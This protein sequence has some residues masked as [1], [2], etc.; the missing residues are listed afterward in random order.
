MMNAFSPAAIKPFEPQDLERERVWGPADMSIARGNRLPAP[1]LPIEIFDETWGDLL[2]L[3]AH[4]K[5]APVDYVAASLL[6][7]A[8]ALLGNSVRGVPWEGWSEATALW[9]G[10]VGIPSSG[11]S[12]ALEVCADLLTRVEREIS[13]GYQADIINYETA[14]QSAAASKEK[15]KLETKEAVKMG[16]PVPAMPATALEP[17]QPIPPQIIVNDTTIEALAHILHGNPRGI[18][19]I[20]DEVSGWIGNLDR[21]GGVGG[22]RAFWLSSYGGRAHKV[23]RVKLGG[24]PLAIPFLNVSIL[25]GIQ[26][27]KLN[28]ALLTGED[29]GLCS[30]FCMVWPDIIPREVPK[31]VPNQSLALEAFRRLRAVPMGTA[32]DGTP[33]WRAVKFSDAARRIFEPWWKAQQKDVESAGGKLQGHFGKYPGFAVRLATIF[34]FLWWAVL[35]DAPEP[36][37]ISDVAVEAAVVLIDRYLKPMAMRCFG[38]AAIPQAERNAT[39]IAR[40][41]L[42]QRASRP[43]K[44]NARQIYKEASLP[45][46][47][48]AEPVKEALAVLVD[49]GWL[50]IAERGGHGRPA[51]DYD[52][53]PAVFETPQ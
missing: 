40:W 35:P 34:E 24:K 46:L 39:V 18:V 38:D 2:A 50:R 21:Y 1:K 32:V 44:I 16:R 48:S 7:S 29:D 20:A 25:G 6:C 42:A 27:D 41:I 28:S 49:H 17:E 33:Q 23:N 37:E 10:L 11:K 9:F 14:L 3:S 36:T 19:L 30:R 8:A 51:A 22:D 31:A 4:A 12:P 45:G 43:P 47:S 15:W 26:P 52:I 5:A 13:D 53:N